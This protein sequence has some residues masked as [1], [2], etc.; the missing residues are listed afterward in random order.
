MIFDD[1]CMAF[2]VKPA[3]WPIS[4]APFSMLRRAT[5]LETAYASAI[6]MLSHVLDRCFACFLSR[7]AATRM[8]AAWLVLGFGQHDRPPPVSISAIAVRS[9]GV[10]KTRGASVAHSAV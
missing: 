9:D 2:D 5:S 8:S 1:L 3:L 6:V 7:S 10:H 4:F